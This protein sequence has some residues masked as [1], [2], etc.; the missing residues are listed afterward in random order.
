[1]TIKLLWLP[2]VHTYGL[3]VFAGEDSGRRLFVGEIRMPPEYATAFRALLFAGDATL[4]R[5]T[6]TEAGW[7]DP[8]FGVTRPAA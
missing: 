6:L 8:P 2:G 3:R 5:G 1:M 7:E 4:D